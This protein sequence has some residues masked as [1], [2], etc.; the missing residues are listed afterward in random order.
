MLKKSAV[1]FGLI[2]LLFLCACEAK[3][4][5]ST[6]AA[7]LNSSESDTNVQQ[8]HPSA[9]Q[10]DVSSVD[11]VVRAIYEAI[12]FREGDAPDISRFRS[13]FNPNAQ[14][15]RITQDS[16][17]TMDIE[18][19]TASFR[20]RVETGVLKSFYEAEISRKTHAFGSIAQ[21]FSTYYKRMNTE[22]PEGFIRGINSLQLYYDGQ[23][24][25]ISSILWEDERGDNLIPQEY[26]H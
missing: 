9:D 13:L 1:F 16:V 2:V 20:E 25:W 26:L 24:W 12:S 21:I 3:R 18:S 6:K 17:D 15:I 10:A 7:S 8:T 23:R 14:F 11:A 5:N 22:D 4:S 19:F